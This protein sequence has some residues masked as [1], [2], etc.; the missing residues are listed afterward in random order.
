MTARQR[1]KAKRMEQWFQFDRPARNSSDTY[2]NL[3]VSVLSR[4]SMDA[5][6][7][8]VRAGWPGDLPRGTTSFTGKVQR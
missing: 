2:S 4:E 5:A 8:I 3:A 7:A 6:I 1:R